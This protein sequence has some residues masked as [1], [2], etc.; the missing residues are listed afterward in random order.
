M[1]AATA[2]RPKRKAKPDGEKKRSRGA[3]RSTK[4]EAGEDYGALGRPVGDPI[5]R[6]RR[7]AGCNGRR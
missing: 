5:V 2:T 7:K 4:R 3:Y 6:Q 1:S